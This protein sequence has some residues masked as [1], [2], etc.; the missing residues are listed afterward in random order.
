MIVPPVIFTRGLPSLTRLLVMRF[1]LMRETIRIADQLL[2]P[3]TVFIGISHIQ[4]DMMM[5][6]GAA[7]FLVLGQRMLLLAYLLVNM[8]KEQVIINT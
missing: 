6:Q 3:M 1:A 2:L 4:V 5:E 8:R 7:H